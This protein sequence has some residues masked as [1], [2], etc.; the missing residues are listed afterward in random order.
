[1]NNLDK[2]TKA[3]LVARLKSLEGSDA[4]TVQPPN[5]SHILTPVKE[6]QD[7]KAALDAHSIV[8]ITDARGRITYA[9]DKFCEISKF[10]RSELLGKDH[11]IIL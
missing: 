7:L 2:L 1:M 8:A 6:L 10:S 9:N 11:R 5:D 3:E 4:H